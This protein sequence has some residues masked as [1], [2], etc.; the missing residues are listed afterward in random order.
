V[1]GPAVTSASGTFTA[2]L[3]IP[4]A[5]PGRHTLTAEGQRSLASATVT[6]TVTATGRDGAA[7]PG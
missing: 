7:V 2:K 5:S 3:T 6:F 1:L 4:Q